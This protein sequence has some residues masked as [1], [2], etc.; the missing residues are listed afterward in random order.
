MGD[1]QVDPF[2]Q[3][4]RIKAQ[5]DEKLLA[6]ARSNRSYRDQLVR[7]FDEQVKHFD[8]N[9]AFLHRYLPVT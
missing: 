9:V 6:R 1:L 3:E 2:T 5:E 7:V 8:Q 4:V